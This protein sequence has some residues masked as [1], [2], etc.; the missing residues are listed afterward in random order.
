MTT[1]DDVKECVA[2]ARAQVATLEDLSR[3]VVATVLELVETKYLYVERVNA[4]PKRLRFLTPNFPCAS[5]P[6]TAVVW[7]AVESAARKGLVK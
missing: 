2:K 7:E 3:Q 6:V 4:R 5:D 1:T